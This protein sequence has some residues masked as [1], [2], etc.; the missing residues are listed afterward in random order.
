MA[1]TYTVEAQL[2]ADIS[3]YSSKLTQAAR[4]MSG[5]ES[6]TGSSV[7]NIKKTVSSIGKG[8]AIAGA[9]VTAMGVKSLKSFGTFNQSLNSAAV[10]AG[11]TSKDISG[12]ADVANKM[13]ADL[14]LSAQ[15]SADAM[16]AMARDGASIS[17]I[18][19]EF[20][21]IA[22]AATAAGS[23]LQQTAGVVQNA[24]NIWGKSIGSP[25]QAA[26]TLVTT[27]NLSNASVEDMQHALAT[28][29]ATANLAG[30]SMQ[31]TSSAIGLLTNQGFSAADA[32]QDLN[33][34]ILQMMAP[35]DKAA[36]LMEDLGLSFKD[37][38]GNMKPFKQIALEVAKATDGMGKADKAAALKT[39]F[40]TSGMKAMVPIMKAV[41]DK[42]GDTKTSWDAFTGAVNKSTKSQAVAAKVLSDQAEEMQKNVGAKIEQVG[43]NWESLSNKAMASKSGVS[44]TLLDWTNGTLNWAQSSN[45]VF[46]KVTRDFIGLAPVIGPA[47][48]AIGGFLTSAGKITSTVS[49]AGGALVDGAK[50]TKQFMSNVSAAGGFANWIKQT[51]IWSAA[52]KVATAV[53]TAFTAVQTAGL[54]PWIIGAA[55]IAAVAAALIYWITQTKSGQAAWQ[56]F[57]SWLS[58]TWSGMVEFFQGVWDSITALF[59]ASMDVIKSGWQATVTFFRNLW[60]GIINVFTSVWAGIQSGW[61]TFSSTVQGIWSSTVS[62]FS[63]IWSALTAF[64]TP[65]IDGIVSLWHGFTTT[66]SGIWNGI[67]KIASG[68]WG[69]IKAAVM[70]PILLLLDAMT[71][72]WQQMKADAELIWN[73]TVGSV[74][75][76][77]TGLAQAVSSIVNG[78]S[79]FVAGVWNSIASVT[80]NVW[81]SIKN[82]VVGFVSNIWQSIQNI[83]S[84]IP[85]WINGLW[86]NVKNGVSNAW[87][88]MWQAIVNFANSIIN[89]IKNT[90]SSIPGW[91]S[92]LWNNVKDAVVGAWNGIWQSAGNFANGVVNDISSA[93]NGLANWIGGLW[94]SVKQV[95]YAAMNIDLYGAGKAIMIS[96]WNGLVSLWNKVQNFVVNIAQ[97]IR[98]HKGPINYDRKLLIPAGGAIM[99][100]LNNGLKNGFGDVMQNVSGMAGNI[101]NA[102]SG[103]A[104]Y[105]INAVSDGLNI[106]ND[107]T[108]SVDMSNQQR[109]ATINLSM[110]GSTYRG[111]VDDISNQQGQTATLNRTTI[112]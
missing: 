21:A 27:A 93:W 26:A 64:M 44:S 37:S 42:T 65:I 32:S 3:N 76:I 23:D 29:G 51:K 62:V 105:R 109:P 16:V 34:A 79:S 100:G 2:I 15:D 86:N 14:P 104:D 61:Q 9:G 90:W 75:S 39:I 68:I 102:V 17:D 36:G 54:L 80:S 85:G 40:H 7:S 31:D 92:G 53:Q 52:T 41:R 13:G 99:E 83:W 96:F 108:L 12:L 6:S 70:G 94:D 91:V 84:A 110:G 19:K 38:N 50:A 60:S 59:T 106:G 46:A 72:N 112:V 4:Q 35:S 1:E 48:T 22:Q 55:I 78:I 8:M 66:I 57:T 74:K 33:H 111:F 71:G 98:D 43:G 88:S 20:P 10:I 69:L 95:I 25:Q 18:K 11:G 28:I 49:S 56:A 24:M 58:D 101:A 47:T 30:M 87:N 63:S 67:I 97:W 107:G 5:F 89:G 82:A 73:K 81:N 45:S 77:V 103:S